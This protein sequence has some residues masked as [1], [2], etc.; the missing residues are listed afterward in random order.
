MPA[1]FAWAELESEL[2]VSAWAEPLIEASLKVAGGDAF[3]VTTAALEFLRS[4]DSLAAPMR[5]VRSRG[6][7]RRR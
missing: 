6:R 7:G 1:F 2:T 3:L 4:K 5:R